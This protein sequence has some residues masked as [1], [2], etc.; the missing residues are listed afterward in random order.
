MMHD[1][2]YPIGTFDF[3]K[4]VPEKRF[5]S[6]IDQI[7][8]LPELLIRAVENLS[9]EQLNTSYRPNGW[10]I[11]QVVHHLADTNM[12]AYIR[13]KL[14]MTEDKPTIKTYAE[15]LWAE[16]DDSQLPVEL[17]TKLLEGLH[18]RWVTLLRTLSS[19]SLDREL[20][21]PDLGILT[22]KK[23]IAL[24]AWHGTHHLVQ[25][26]SGVSRMTLGSV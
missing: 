11:R 8:V 26:T 7:E 6:L 14:A 18:K 1:L 21:H 17:S 9:E 25:I 4:E 24:Y 12:N 23:L 19:S 22:I 2:Q 5:K 3:N 16:L 15:A 20:I 10:T 13:T